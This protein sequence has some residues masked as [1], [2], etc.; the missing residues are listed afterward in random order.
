MI[1]IGILSTNIFFD[2]NL[3]LYVTYC[4]PRR[5][6]FILSGCSAVISSDASCC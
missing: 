6:T 5:M 4:L 2:R 1:K 3:Q